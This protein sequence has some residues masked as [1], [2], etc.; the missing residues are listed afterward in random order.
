ML[1][2]EFPDLMQVRLSWRKNQGMDGRKIQQARIGH[3][4]A[5][6]GCDKHQKR[7]Q[8]G[9]V[10]KNPQGIHRKS[11]ARAVEYLQQRRSR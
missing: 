10:R 8:Q 3:R 7:Q 11:G 5:A 4:S 6:G 2:I 1:D 9:N